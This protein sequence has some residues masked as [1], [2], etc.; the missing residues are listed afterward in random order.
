MNRKTGKQK[1]SLL[2][3]F[4]SVS[5]PLKWMTCDL[6]VHLSPRHREVNTFTCG[7]IFIIVHFPYKRMNYN[8]ILELLLFLL[9]LKI[10]P[11]PWSLWWRDLFWGG[12]FCHPYIFCL[13]NLLKK[14][15][16][17]ESKLVDYSVHHWSSLLFLGT[18]EIS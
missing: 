17:P 3:R 9:F 8:L 16:S 10:F 18:G 2:Y 6:V 11:L 5:S 13:W 14:F 12:I 1:E 15:H 7:D 4:K